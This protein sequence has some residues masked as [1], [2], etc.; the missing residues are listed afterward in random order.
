MRFTKA[1]IA[2]NILYKKSYEE[3]ILKKCLVPIPTYLLE[4]VN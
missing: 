1:F 3:W 4:K 2:N